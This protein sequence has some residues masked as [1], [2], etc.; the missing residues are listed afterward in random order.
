M[1]RALLYENYKRIVMPLY[2]ITFMII[3]IIL[4]INY[5]I[6][7][8]SLFL[9][10]SSLACTIYS[11]LLFF[12]GITLNFEK[13]EFVFLSLSKYKRL[14]FDEIVAID[15]LDDDANGLSFEIIVEYIKNNKLEKLKVW[16]SRYYNS[17][18]STKKHKQIQ[19]LKNK[20]NQI[21]K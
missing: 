18:F 4:M 9:I 15:F 2:S 7:Y 1:Y 14:K 6:N 10:L 17:K 8:V 16:W 3:G 11:I 13:K 21:K 20:L 12:Y 5:P 19:E